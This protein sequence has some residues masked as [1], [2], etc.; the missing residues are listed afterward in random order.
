MLLVRRWGSSAVE[1]GRWFEHLTATVLCETAGMR[2]TRK[3][4]PHDD[5][6]DLW[7][8]DRDVACWC[9]VS[10]PT[11]ICVRVGSAVVN[12][13]MTVNGLCPC[14]VDCWSGALAFA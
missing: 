10:Y 5:G 9:D 12:T 6:A 11:A 1:R 2:L 3:G 7:V 14:V 8:R 4:G 13:V